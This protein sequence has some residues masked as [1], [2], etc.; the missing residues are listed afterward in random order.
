MSLK[1]YHFSDF[2]SQV[3]GQL[4]QLRQLGQGFAAYSDDMRF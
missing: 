4:G 3:Q 2:T 1:A